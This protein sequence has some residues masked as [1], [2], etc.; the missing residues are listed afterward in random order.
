MRRRAIFVLAALALVLLGAASWFRGDIEK[1]VCEGLRDGVWA[2]VGPGCLTSACYEQGTC[3][4]R[5]H[6]P[7]Y[8]DRVRIGDHISRV[9]LH[10]GN[11]DNIDGENLSWPI[12]K[13]GGTVGVTARIK[14]N[15]LVAISCPAYPESRLVE[16][17][18]TE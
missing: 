11:P 1:T 16:A 4:Y 2:T 8:C 9:Y 14:R 7:F 10:L 18:G 3:R 17:E 13:E 15:H 12:G 6:P 5:T